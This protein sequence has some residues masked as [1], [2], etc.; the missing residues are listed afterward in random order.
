[1]LR[2]HWGAYH[3]PADEWT[4]DFPFAGPARYADFAYRVG[5]AAATG[6]RQ[7]MLVAP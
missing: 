2:R 5:M 1:M 3:N 4:P 7:R 6:A